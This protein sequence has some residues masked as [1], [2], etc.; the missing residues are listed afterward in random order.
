MSIAA[1]LNIISQNPFNQ[2]S[3]FE[4]DLEEYQNKIDELLE[5]IED[6]FTKQDYQIDF[7]IAYSKC[8]EICLNR[9]A[10]ELYT[11]VSKLLTKIILSYQEALIKCNDNDFMNNLIQ[12]FQFFSAK[13]IQ[14]SDVLSY[15]E[16]VKQKCHFFKEEPVLFM[17]TQ[18]FYQIVIFEEKL[19]NKI[20]NAMKVEYFKI[21][22][23]NINKIDIFH[24]YFQ[25][26]I[27]K[28]YGSVFFNET[29]CPIIKNEAKIYY[30]NYS[31]N[32]KDKLNS[33]QNKQ[34][35]PLI[36]K[37]Y[38]DETE[39]FLLTE[40][41]LLQKV[42]E[43]EDI[44]NIIMDNLIISNCDV[45]YKKG[46][47]KFFKKNDL[48][49]FKTFYDLIFKHQVSDLENNMNRFYT[50]F[51]EM[52]QKSLK[53]LTNTFV[54]FKKNQTLEYF[55]FY[56]YVEELCD[57]KQKYTNF[58][59]NTMNNNQKIEHIIKNSF[60]RQVNQ[61]TEFLFSFIKLIHEEIKLCQKIRSNNRI[62]EF[63][64]K[65]LTIFKLINDK[66]LFENEYRKALSKRLIRN[67][68][69]IKE[70]EVEFYKIMKKE[71]GCNYVKKLENMIH[72][73][74]YSQSINFDFRLNNKKNNLQQN[75]DFYIKIVS[76]DN[77]PLEK[78]LILNFSSEKIK[79]TEITEKSINITGFPDSLKKC[80]K[81]FANFY[82][83]KFTNR[84]IS[85]VS[86]LS[87]I[88]LNA[89]I[90]DK[91]YSLIVSIYQMILLMFYNKKKSYYIKSIIE[92]TNL[93]EEKLKEVYQPL[94]KSNILLLDDKDNNNNT[95]NFNEKFD[96]EEARINLNYKCKDKS[97][98]KQEDKKDK[99]VSHFLI[100][101]RKYQIDA[102]IIHV[103]KQAKK[104][105]FDELKMNV[106]QEVKGYFI[107]EISLIKS[108]L[109]NLMDRN[110]IK[111]D[112]QKPD[113]YIYI[114]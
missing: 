21:R 112:D 50:A 99:E 5:M 111:R 95:L 46:A 17:G 43:K 36:I 48:I 57:L 90:N 72:D 73:I 41:K 27:D 82:Y 3:K 110:F 47:K 75:I 86:E 94:I 84:Y 32:F 83:S 69:M 64:N 4:P 101:D 16:R 14:I 85:F 107:P 88:E 23:G 106:T 24:S 60:E 2:Y 13:M 12:I 102:S 34:E 114:A 15:L 22:N 113:V 78:N 98:N 51:T 55:N 9:M 26:L 91:N 56:Q 38:L 105:S 68:S 93:S 62:K 96:S 70:M 8:H 42:S 30:E 6:Q 7:Q 76:Q 87:W 31:K 109:D 67:S 19:K 104:L 33:I 58:L 11:S 100:E 39:S 53:K 28:K 49:S 71:S 10:K 77:W 61:N 29:I 18:L 37:K 45:L 81:E 108:R 59:K 79:N 35:I 103:L 52:L 66:D 65:F 63:S 80:F 89:K 92:M 97:K 40:E 20:L 44:L 25:I 1:N 74:F 54:I